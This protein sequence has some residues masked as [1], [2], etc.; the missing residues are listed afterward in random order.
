MCTCLL[1][2]GECCFF[3]FF[4]VAPV[5]HVQPRHY[6]SVLLFVCLF[7]PIEIQRVAGD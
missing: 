5:R 3:F 4:K 1:C 6:V 2:L 7:F